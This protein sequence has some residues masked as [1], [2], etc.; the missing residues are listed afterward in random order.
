VTSP[1]QIFLNE[2]HS[3]SHRAIRD[4]TVVQMY[5]FYGFHRF[6]GRKT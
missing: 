3:N 2:R 5:P 1:L 4:T 6:I